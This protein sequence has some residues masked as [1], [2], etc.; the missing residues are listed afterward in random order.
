MKDTLRKIGAVVRNNPVG[1]L[2][3]HPLIKKVSLVDAKSQRLYYEIDVDTTTKSISI[4]T[5]PLPVDDMHILEFDKGG[6]TFRYFVGAMKLLPL[7]AECVKIKNN[8][9]V[10]NHFS[11]CKMNVEEHNITDPLLLD[12]ADALEQNSAAIESFINTLEVQTKAEC[13]RREAHN[14]TAK[15][16]GKLK[17]CGYVVNFTINGKE[18]YEYPELMD[19]IDQTF[20]DQISKPVVVKGVEYM[21]LTNVLYGFFKTSHD[22]NLAQTPDFSL[23]DSYKSF[24][25]TRSELADLLYGGKF[26]TAQENIV[27]NFG[28]T[29]LPRMDNLSYDILDEFMNIR[30]AGSVDKSI[31][32]K[33]KFIRE[34]NEPL[35]NRPL[36]ISDTIVKSGKSKSDI[37][38]DVI[39]KLKGGNTTQDLSLISNVNVSRL[40][41][42][43]NRI[44][45][46]QQELDTAPYTL[47]T[48]FIEF[49]K[50]PKKT[51]VKEYSSFILKWTMEIFNDR[52]YGNPLI[53]KVFIEK[54]EYIIRNEDEFLRSSYNR[55][56]TNYKYLKY[57][58]VKGK[59]VYQSIMDS[60]S[61]KL[62][63]ELG[64]F[65]Q[66]WQ[67]SH[68]NNRKNLVSV[69]KNYNG[70]MS[71]RVYNMTSVASFYNDIQSRLN[72]NSCKS[73]P[74]NFMAQFEALDDAITQKQDRF[75]TQK[76]ILG[77][78]NAQYTYSKPQD[79]LK[80][81]V[82]VEAGVGAEA[83]EENISV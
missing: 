20:I 10:F 76:F 36:R 35:L 66:T 9:R 59:Q 45:E 75:D 24:P 65:C 52:F 25:I 11:Y 1:R 79:A 26:H 67:T 70:Y 71:R 77:Y 22:H 40:E 56:L 72:R 17:P 3:Y 81:G 49:L 68:D 83:E 82:V 73:Y 62:G 42:L 44:K 8:K 21:I 18:F 55:L 12:Y 58:Q 32:G 38:F 37:Q 7:G 80:E 34:N 63:Y 74:R 27:E 2:K 29:F 78:F 61:Y 4:N 28:L 14:K 54:A 51:D 33:S 57:M 47:S 46:I 60:A 41:R 5:E 39:F 69:I 43:N 15:K 64:L 31:V 48:G 53:D 30:N 6:K 23:D 16:D 50:K 13:A 19:T